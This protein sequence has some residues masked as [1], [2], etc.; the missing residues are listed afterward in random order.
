MNIVPI[1]KS[2]TRLDLI[3]LS[4][5]AVLITFNPYYLNRETDIFE[6]GL[7]LPGINAL[8][9]GAV[10]Y[11]DF[12]HLRGPLDLYMPALLMKVFKP[13]VAVLCAYFYFGN[14]LCLVLT[15]FIARELL[16][17]RCMFYLM[18]PAMV[19][20]TFPRVMFPFWGGMRYA[21]GLMA[22][23]CLI[24]FFKNHR[25][26]WMLGAG[27]ISSLG[28][29]TSIEIGIYA[30]VGI[31]AALSVGWFLKIY[32]RRTMIKAAGMYGLGIAIVMGPWILYALTQ[33]AFIPYVNDALAVILKMQKVI[34]PHAAS[35]YPHNFAEAFTAMT[36]P[37]SINFKQMTPS[38]VY[39]AVL[40][41]LGWRFKKHTFGPI[42][43]CLL[44]LSIYGFIMYNTAFRGIWT[45]HF[46]MALMP[47][48]ILYFFLG[49]TLVLFVW[50]NRERWWPKFP[51]GIQAKNAILCFILLA[52]FISSTAYAITRYNHR[53]FAFQFIR[54]VLQGKNTFPLERTGGNDTKTLDIERARGIPVPS[55][56]AEEIEAVVGFLK[57]HSAPRDI[58]VLFPELGVYNFLADRPFLG[59]FP[60]TTF[61][62]FDDRW[63]EEFLGQLK[64]GRARYIFVQKQMQEG[65]KLVYFAWKP[66]QHKYD[67]MISAVQKNYAV[68]AETPL[69]YIYARKNKKGAL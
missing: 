35:V 39:L 53:F 16:K 23:W 45:A 31:I 14:V 34:D 20:R 37:W 21:F 27:I 28:L 46:E 2:P 10:P 61:S 22:M 30:L 65:W 8:M 33:H 7:Y 63:Y 29:L 17:T 43:T 24:K 11:R 4:A 26:P 68:S 51:G 12:F 62:W 6:L 15:V 44:A 66:N 57:R 9:H 67:Q 1:L 38:Y 54:N 49:E 48:K 5:F 52:L 60:I 18:V 50:S 42:E 13:H 64:S 36:N 56:Q 59:R 32:E 47:E 19:A 25:P 41:Y 40:V 55:G 58:V 69:C 3:I